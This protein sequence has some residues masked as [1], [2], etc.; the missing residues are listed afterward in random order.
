MSNGYELAVTRCKN[1]SQPRKESEMNPSLKDGTLDS[2]APVKVLMSTVFQR[3]QHKGKGIESFTSA[4]EAEIEELCLILKSVDDS[5]TANVKWVKAILPEYPKVQAF[6]E[7]CSRLRHYSF[8][9][10]K[11]SKSDCKICKKPRL[12]GNVFEEINFLPDPVPNDNGHYKSFSD[13]YGTKTSEEH[14]PSIQKKPAKQKTLPFSASVQHARNTNIMIQCEECEKWCLLYSKVKLTTVEQ[15]Q[16][17]TALSDFT[18]TCSANLV[19]LHLSGRWMMFSY[20][21]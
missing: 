3:L 11:C 4:T 17:N 16:L 21:M 7:N 18:Y 8:C 10:K 15:H 12:P 2:V 13:V 5:I 20:E 9:V 14:R 19:D 1:M 6:I